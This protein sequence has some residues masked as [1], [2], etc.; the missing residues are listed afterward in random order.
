MLCIA[1]AAAV[2]LGYLPASGFWSFL[3]LTLMQAAMLAPMTVLADA[4]ALGAA[5]R[6]PFEYGWVRGTGSAA[7]IAGTLFL[8]QAI[9][10]WGLEAIIWAQAAL[11]A[12]AAS[13]ARFVP[14]LDPIREKS[15]THMPA[16]RELLRIPLY[17]DLVLMAA[18]VLG[19]HAMHDAFAVIRWS[20]AGVSPGAAS[21]LWSLAVIAEVLVFFTVGPAVVERLGLGSQG[22]WFMAALCALAWPLAWRLRRAR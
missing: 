20:A 17:R 18:L 13:C 4:L 16:V 11:L 9:V 6:A 15:R 12:I 1:L 19:S 5:K 22:F 7:F 2:T 3:A 21:V 10:A 8:G 14:N